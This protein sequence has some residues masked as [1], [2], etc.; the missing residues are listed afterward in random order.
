ML[1]AAGSSSM[2]ELE[3]YP[4]Q[5]LSAEKWEFVLGEWGDT[6]PLCLTQGGL[7]LF[8]PLLSHGFKQQR[9]FKLLAFCHWRLAPYLCIRKGD[10]ISGVTLSWAAK[11]G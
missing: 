8:S 9:N 7:V 3:V 2:L 1:K 5:S 11:Q 4:E 10:I 6:G